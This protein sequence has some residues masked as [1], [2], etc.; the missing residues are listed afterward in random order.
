MLRSVPYWGTVWRKKERWMESDWK[1]TV[2]LLF[3]FLANPWL[4]ETESAQGKWHPCIWWVV[5]WRP[6]FPTTILS[7]TSLACW[8]VNNMPGVKL[9]AVHEKIFGG[10]RHACVVLLCQCASVGVKLVSDRKCF[11][12]HCGQISP[13]CIFSLLT[14]VLTPTHPLPERRKETK[15]TCDCLI[16]TLVWGIFWISTQKWNWGQ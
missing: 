4:T 16:F 11:N 7:L 13:P 8:C 12:V 14:C 6:G 1:Y 3:T 9:C 2:M 15:K 10:F 5:E